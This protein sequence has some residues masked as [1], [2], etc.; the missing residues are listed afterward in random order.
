MSCRSI[1]LTSYGQVI[2]FLL[3][4]KDENTLQLFLYSRSFVKSILLS[5]KTACYEPISKGRHCKMHLLKEKKYA[6]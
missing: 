1:E 5:S 3:N 4:L 2:Q 6:P